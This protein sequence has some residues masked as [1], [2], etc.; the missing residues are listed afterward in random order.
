MA[1]KRQRYGPVADACIIF[2]VVRSAFPFREFMPPHQRSRRQQPHLKE[3]VQSA[4]RE[5]AACVWVV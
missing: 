3:D 5:A 2:T 1:L 4:F